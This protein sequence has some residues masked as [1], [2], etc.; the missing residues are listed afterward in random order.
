M[1]RQ[2]FG[3]TWWGQKWLNSLEEISDANRLPRG[4]TYARNG[5]VQE[6]TMQNNSFKAKVQGSI[7]TP[8]KVDIKPV[9][10]TNDEKKEIIDLIKKQPSLVS[11]LLSNRLPETLHSK[12]EERD[13]DI[14]PKSWGDLNGTC[15]CPDSASPCKHMAAVIYLIANEIDQ[16]PFLFFQLKGIDLVTELQNLGYSSKALKPSGLISVKEIFSRSSSDDQNPREN[17]L[18]ENLE[19]M[20][21]FSQISELKEK[22]FS[23]LTA[24]P[25]FYSSKDFKQLLSE[26][27]R[28]FA[29]QTKV[30]LMKRTYGE[31]HNE[32]LNYCNY[33]KLTTTS[34]SN[35]TL[36]LEEIVIKKDLTFQQFCI[37]FLE[38]KKQKKKSFKD[39]SE[40]ISFI[41]GI[42][43]SYLEDYDQSRRFCLLLYQFSCNLMIKGAFIP[44]LV[45]LEESNE[46]KIRWLPFFNDQDVKQVFEN[47]LKHSGTQIIIEGFPE[48]SRK[49]KLITLTS[50]FL[51]SLVESEAVNV[52]ETNL[53]DP[54]CEMFFQGKTLSSNSS[55][56]GKEIPNT[57]GFWLF[58]F[59]LAERDF[60][61]I[62]K[63]EDEGIEGFSAEIFIEL[64]KEVLPIS[65]EKIMS[66]KKYNT[67]KT[68]LLKDF[69]LIN[70]YLPLVSKIVD[71]QGK[72]KSYIPEKEFAEI[73][74]QI[75]PLLRFLGLQILLPKGLQKLLIPQL[76][77][78]S[79]KKVSQTTKKFLSFDKVIDFDWQISLGDE[80]LTK[81]E[82]VKLVKGKSGIVK[83]KSNYVYLQ[84]KEIENLLQDLNKEIPS[85]SSNELLQ[86]SLSG[87]HKGR[88]IILDSNSRKLID[89]LIKVPQVEEPKN[90]KAELR[91]YQQR[92]YEWLYKNIKTGFGSLIADDMG[93]GKTIQVVSTCLRLKEEKFFNKKP[94]LIVVPTT[95]LI[96]W[97]K[98]LQKFA[99]S[100]KF[101]IYHGSKRE[102]AQKSY[103]LIITT[104]GI[105]R[106][107]NKK[108]AENEWSTIILDEAHNIK[109]PET[110][111]AK[112]IKSLK[113]QSKI[114]MTGTPV[115]NRLTEYW[116]I[117][118]FANPGYLG[119]LTHF[120]EHYALPIEVNREK[121]KIESFKKITSPFILRRLKT[122]KKI[123]SDLPDKVETE[124]YCS[125]TKEQ[126]SLYQ[127]ILDDCMNKIEE[128]EG[129]ERKGL[130]LKLITSLKQVCNHPAHFLKQEFADVK[131]S[132]KT[133]RLMEILEEILEHRREKTLIFTQYR[134]MGDILSSMISEQFGYFCNFLHG[135]VNR[136]KRDEMVETFQNDDSNKLMILSLKA[137]G[138]G[139]NLTAANNVIHFDRW[140][141]PAVEAQATDRVYRI[142][143]QKKVLVYPF[144][145]KGTFEE[146]INEMLLEKRELASLTVSKGEQWIGDFSNKELKEMFC[147]TT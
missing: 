146:K 115:E 50:L 91:P 102:L 47:F 53:K 135:G 55:I 109:N 34:C 94:G 104:Y 136:K 14:F 29:L 48:A 60:V 8:Y 54:V 18:N 35:T 89:N 19:N 4:R 13:I 26:F 33:K 57:I 133:Q 119:N 122:D 82:F 11:E 101:C 15:S 134:E 28:S 70:E 25:L 120:K 143:Q 10:F 41:T 16:N 114:A 5:S 66:L 79:K 99:P 108:F 83:L 121:E 123:L 65:L 76:T 117:F 17:E 32:W 95:L 84:E 112:S 131:S 92:G 118:D 93:L 44:Q 125:L 126:S 127:S 124:E 37:S 38:A 39:F 137:G 139:L 132:G 56:Q 80:S 40:F 85:L 141:N 20:V 71:S 3:K 59:F 97:E 46:Y 73:F 87:K 62:I 68:H 36:K 128:S 24:S 52:K 107:E 98:E 116:S 6:I 129:I 49:E 31:E 51:S 113:S 21:D 2:L 142:G 96:N 22:V 77:L 110:A 23:L 78:K 145:C 144:I 63:F 90:L 74:F 88:K 64:K 45:E 105:V 111:Q 140:W 106:S 7:G 27:Y 86:A 30:A 67:I 75:I 42:E 69:A 9:L 43:N 103:D 147:L 100:L 130:I 12:I 81:E 138:V 61:P 58:K 72:E 1:S